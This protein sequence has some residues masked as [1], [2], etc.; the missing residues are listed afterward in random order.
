[1]DPNLTL[2]HT[3]HNTAVILLHQGIAYPAIA[4]AVLPGQAAFNIIGRNMSRSCFGD[5]H[6]WSA[7]PALLFH[8]HQSP[9]L[10]LPVYCR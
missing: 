7:V 5:Q 4:L 10:L 8:P 1:M 6:D 3:T 9:I 2:A